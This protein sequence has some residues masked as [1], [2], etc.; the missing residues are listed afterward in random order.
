MCGTLQ[1]CIEA[2]LSGVGDRRQILVPLVV[3]V[4]WRDLQRLRRLAHVAVHLGLEDVELR[5]RPAD[6]DIG[7]WV[8]FA[9]AG[10]CGRAHATQPIEADVVAVLVRTCADSIVAWPAR[11]RL[12]GENARVARVVRVRPHAIG[13]AQV[14]GPGKVALKPETGPVTR[15]LHA[16]WQD[17]VELTVERKLTVTPSACEK[18]N[19]RKKA[20]QTHM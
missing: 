18:T 10:A 11:R 8:I 19:K 4:K 13:G 17:G 7:T 16:S 2:R 14:A 6:V 1:Y 5:C 9:S 20:G 3:E 15:F 12:V